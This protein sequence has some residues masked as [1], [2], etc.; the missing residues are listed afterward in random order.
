MVSAYKLAPPELASALADLDV[1]LV[2]SSRKREVA[3][4]NLEAAA[5][6][7]L[8]MP[9]L[10]VAVAGATGAVALPPFSSSAPSSPPFR[11]CASLSVFYFAPHGAVPRCWWRCRMWA[12]GCTRSSGPCTASC[13]CAGEEER[14]RERDTPSEG[15]RGGWSRWSRGG[16][17]YFV[18]WPN[19]IGVASALNPAAYSAVP[20]SQRLRR[21]PFSDSARHPP[22][23]LFTS[24]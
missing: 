8:L 1:D 2:S 19:T 18:V 4:T 15:K 5:L 11:P 13:R 22:V 7:F 17:V 12:Y 20:R 23:R 3:S 21:A 9:V 16:Y 6:V 10:S 14:E 24:P